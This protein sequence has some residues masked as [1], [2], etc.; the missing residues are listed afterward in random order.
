MF[1]MP[2]LAIRICRQSDPYVRW[3]LTAISLGSC[4]VVSGLYRVCMDSVLRSSTAKPSSPSR[5]S[6]TLLCDVSTGRHSRH[7]W[8]LD[9]D[10]A[11]LSDVGSL[12]DI[13]Y[14]K[15]QYH[16]WRILYSHALPLS[17]AS[18]LLATPNHMWRCRRLRVFHDHNHAVELAS[19]PRWRADIGISIVSVTLLH[20]S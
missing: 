12:L 2:S 6:L 7:L 14:N 13:V 16:R 11:P 9:R 3:H 4:W 5:E 20:G 1:C 10:N 19:R 15:R 17:H 8:I 18:L